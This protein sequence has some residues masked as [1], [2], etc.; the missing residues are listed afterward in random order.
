MT[1][2]ENKRFNNGTFMK[3]IGIIQ[4]IANDANITDLDIICALWSDSKTK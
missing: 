3:R 4:K 1:T 2:N